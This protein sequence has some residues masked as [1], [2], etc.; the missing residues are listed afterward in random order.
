M[1]QQ[2]EAETVAGLWNKKAK[3]GSISEYDASSDKFLFKG[4]QKTDW[5]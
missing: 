4:G 3:N 1:R 2:T 5:P